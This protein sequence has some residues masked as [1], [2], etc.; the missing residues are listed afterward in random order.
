MRAKH[1]VGLQQSSTLG[2]TDRDQESRTETARGESALVIHDDDAD[3]MMR[4]EVT[5]ILDPLQ[6]LRYRVLQGTTSP[7]SLHGDHAR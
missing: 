4:T 2:I 6:G 7:E 1:Q 3:L 5:E